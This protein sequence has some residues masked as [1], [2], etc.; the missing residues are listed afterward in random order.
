MALRRTNAIGSSSG[1]YP[2]S[3]AAIRRAV[4]ADGVA[5]APVIDGRGAALAAVVLSTDDPE[6]IVREVSSLWS[7]AQRTFLTIGR[8]LLQARSGIERRLVAETADISDSDRRALAHRDYKLLILDRLPFGPKVAHQL[9]SVARAVF[10][11]KRIDLNDLPLSYSV[12]YQ[13]TTLSTDEFEAA[14][15][16]GLVGP[17]ARREALIEFK[18]RKRAAAVERV[19]ELRSRKLRLLATMERLQQELRAVVSELG[20]IDKND[21]CRAAGG[22]KKNDALSLGTRL[23]QSR[24]SA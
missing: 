14:R 24:K 7:Q 5:H 21:D 9:E 23:R 18:R 3:A 17:A 15:L 22:A 4:D 11:T 16:E 6:L 19:A 20:E 1:P 2:P 12:A 13:L 8:Y 10:E